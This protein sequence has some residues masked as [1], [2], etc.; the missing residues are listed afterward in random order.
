MV[1][2]M[3][4]ARR[5]T[6]RLRTFPRENQWDEKRWRIRLGPEG[7]KGQAAASRN[8]PLALLREKSSN[9][10][11]NNPEDLEVEQKHGVW[12]IVVSARGA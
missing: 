7:K 8:R 5:G 4:H 11:L 3:P 1:D 9:W 10:G 12:T 6:A 2:S